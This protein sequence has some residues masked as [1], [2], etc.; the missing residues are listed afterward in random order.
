MENIEKKYPETLE[1][2]PVKF[3]KLVSGE[4]IIAYVHEEDGIDTIGI[5]EPMQM[6]IE[7]EQQLI[8]SPYLPFS[9]SKLHFMDTHNIMFETEVSLDIKAYYMR[10]ILDMV[11]GNE[12]EKH[13]TSM[14]IR[15]NSSIH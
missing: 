1:D 13:E 12:R 11:E 3:F 7:D 8:F 6:I 9:D 4:S 2:V 14:A 10:I 5:E 15:G